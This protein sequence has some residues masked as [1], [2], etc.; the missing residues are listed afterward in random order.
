VEIGRVIQCVGAARFGPE[1]GLIA[2]R[3]YLRTRPSLRFARTVSGFPVGLPGSGRFWCLIQSD[4]QQPL[5]SLL[6]RQE[7]NLQPDRY[8]R[9]HIDQFR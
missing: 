3:P 8:E 4:V 6:G 1:N 5:I 2:V 7:Q 9:Q